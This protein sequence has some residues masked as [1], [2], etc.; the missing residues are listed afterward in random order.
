RG[1][2][3]TGGKQSCGRRRRRI[4]PAGKARR[5][6]ASQRNRSGQKAAAIENA[7]NES[8]LQL[9][10]LG[11]AFYKFFCAAAG[12]GDRKAAVVV[13]ALDRN[14]RSHSVLRVANLLPQ[15]GIGV[16]AGTK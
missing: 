15:K 2:E 3:G 6:L 5:S 16:R 1:E 4:M 14:D 9:L 11:V 10:Q 12:K 13:F 8:P 7:P